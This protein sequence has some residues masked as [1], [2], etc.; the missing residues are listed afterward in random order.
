MKIAVVMTTINVPTVLALYKQYVLG[1]T[2][3]FVAGDLKTP[4]AARDFC[5]PFVNVLY[6]PPDEQKKW[7]SSEIIGWNT[8]SRRNFAVLEALRWGADL[9]ISVDDDMIPHPSF[10]ACFEILFQ[11]KWSGLQLGAPGQWFDHGSYTMPP[12]RARGLP[13]MAQ[14]SMPPSQVEGVH[15]V[16]I[17]AA[18]G[19]ILGVP[20]TDAKAAL[21][22]RPF[23]RGVS[24]ILRYGFVTHPQA[25]SVFN[26]QVTAF[27]RELAPGFAQFYGEQGRNTDIFASLFMRS[28]M[29]DLGW[30]THYGLP[31]AYHNR[32][33]RD[34]NKDLEA[35]QWG[36]EN[37]EAFA[38]ELDG[39]KQG[40]ISPVLCSKVL[41]EKNQKMYDLW[42]EDCREAMA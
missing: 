33:V 23:I 40:M 16:T 21:G 11:G 39:W 20:D 35:E 14:F 27:R 9:I 25:Y 2:M 36:V 37:I 22:Q 31:M 5:L 6:Y 30:Y 41:S 7:R 19:I 10:F 38:K 29:R 15:D 24:D 28:R 26:S 17:G 42:F 4:D 12:A 18:Q 13:A 1:D 32:S 3:F 8:D 34:L